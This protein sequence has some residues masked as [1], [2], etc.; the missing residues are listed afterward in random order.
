MPSSGL[1][2]DI[3]ETALGWVAAVVSER[4]A[5]RMS[6]PEPSFERARDHVR[7]EID[8]AELA[9]EA[10]SELREAVTAYCAGEEVDLSV[11]PIDTSAA[12]PFFA[13]AWESCR[14]IPPGETRSYAWL[15]AAAGSPRAARGA[16]QAMARNR[17]AL[18]VP[19]HR[20]IAA[21]GGLG[22]FGGSQGLSMKVRLLRLESGRRGV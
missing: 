5:V 22:G 11:F 8:G 9:P 14:T 21:D 6:L 15:A 3:F 17:V 2:F 10:V 20:V 12:S 16:G 4:G 13:S 7:P 19:C 1:R 18:L